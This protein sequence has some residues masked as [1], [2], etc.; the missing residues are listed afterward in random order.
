MANAIPASD[1]QIPWRAILAAVN[2][3]YRVTPAMIALVALVPLYIVIPLLNDG[4]TAFQPALPVDHL[5]PQQ[6]IW[7]LIYG[8][9]YLWLILLPVFVLCRPDHIDRTIRAYLMVWLA[10]YAVFIAIPT[11]APRATD[12]VDGEGFAAWGLRMLYEM[13]TPYNCFPSLH[14]AHSFVS[15]LSAWRLH[16]GLGGAA[17]TAAALV[18][19]STLFTKQHYLVDLAGGTLLAYLAYVLFLR[20][21][22]RDAASETERRI[23][24]YVAAAITPIVAGL[25]AIYWGL[26][27]SGL[28]P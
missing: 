5:I 16:R 17:I 10:S 20:R 25:M 24:P 15:A 27:A 28:E 4:R 12:D 23:A 7:V 2:R 13:D 19:V 1:R 9:L 11:A 6:P 8:P 21:V 14:V 22:S 18:A 26:Y 3:P